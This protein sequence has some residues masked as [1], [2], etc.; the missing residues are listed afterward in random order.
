MPT[1]LPVGV[2]NRIHS[3]RPRSRLYSDIPRPDAPVIYTGT[4]PI[5]IAWLGR[6]SIYNTF[7]NIFSVSEHNS[8]TE[9]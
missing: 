8:V 1:L 9:V 7:L 6:R 3:T 5:L 2:T 4:F